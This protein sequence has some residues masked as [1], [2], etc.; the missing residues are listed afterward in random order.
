MKSEI[1]NRCKDAKDEALSILRNDQYLLDE[2]F[3]LYDNMVKKLDKVSND[4]L[5]DL[6]EQ[7]L[8]HGAK[9]QIITKSEIELADM[10][11]QYLKLSEQE[12]YSNMLQYFS[13]IDNLSSNDN[14]VI[15]I[16]ISSEFFGLYS[17]REEALVLKQTETINSNREIIEREAT[18]VI[19]DIIRK[20]ETFKVGLFKAYD[21]TINSLDKNTKSI[22]LELVENYL[23]ST[24]DKYISTIDKKDVKYIDFI[25]KT[26]DK[27][28]NF[29]DKTRNISSSLIFVYDSDENE[30]RI[31][32]NVTFIGL[33][34]L[35][36]E[37]TLEL[38]KERNKREAQLKNIA[39]QNIIYHNINS[40][41]DGDILDKLYS[42]Y[43][44]IV[45]KLK[46]TN[47]K[48]D[49]NKVLYNMIESFLETGIEYFKINPSKKDFEK[50]L[51]I[52]KE[53]EKV[54]VFFEIND[55]CISLSPIFSI[56]YLDSSTIFIELQH[57]FVGFFLL[58]KQA[59][60][61]NT[62]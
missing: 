7:Y 20:D 48:T 50:T 53:L 55:E 13:P 36:K 21:K 32:V 27:K 16:V 5:I 60:E 17:L 56:G 12:I 1:L 43:D 38:A 29:K 23:N 39:L 41:I 35:K 45:D 49:I 40:N 6:M 34:L 18:K 10:Y 3:K 28:I 37:V 59:L 57:T 58:R 15:E 54:K 9:I 31:Q 42:V 62:N 25:K 47:T 44:D 52:Y 14:G 30:K 4:T 46:E 22:L 24:N 2:V 33:F 11:E 26:I 61:N 8:E 19:L 51:L